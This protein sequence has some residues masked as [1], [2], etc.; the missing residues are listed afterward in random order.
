M[1]PNKEGS[2]HDHPHDQ[3]RRIIEG[4]VE[5]YTYFIPA[6]IIHNWTIALSAKILDIVIKQ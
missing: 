1:A 4:G 6:G 5:R 2:A 3:C